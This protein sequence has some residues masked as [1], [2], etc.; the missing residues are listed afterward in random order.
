M[1][2]FTL[3]ELLIVII[4]LL[5]GVYSCRRGRPRRRPPPAMRQQSATRHSGSPTTAIL[6][7]PAPRHSGFPHCLEIPTFFQFRDHFSSK[8]TSTTRSAGGPFLRRLAQPRCIIRATTPSIASRYP[9]SPPLGSERRFGRSVHHQWSSVR[10]A[11]MCRMPWCRR[12]L[13]YHSP[14]YDQSARAKVPRRLRGRHRTPS[15]TP[16]NMP[17]APTCP[18]RRSVTRTARAYCVPVL[19]LAAAAHDPAGQAFSALVCTT[20]LASRATRTARAAELFKNPRSSSFH[21]VTPPM[22][23]VTSPPPTH[24]HATRA[25]AR[26]PVCTRARA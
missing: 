26:A 2:G 22:I 13:H 25:R 17:V 18:R 24:A 11:W 9:S 16:R 3:I 7:A 14:A 23:P 1:R 20:P 12:S 15:F 21:C 4:A 19:R 5:I 6:S 8:E 10:R